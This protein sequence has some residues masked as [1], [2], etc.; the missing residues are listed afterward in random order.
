MLKIEGINKRFGS[1]EACKGINLEVRKGECFY[2][3]GP[4]GCGK[5]TLLSMI[6]GHLSPDSGDII[7]EGHSLLNMP[8][9][10]RPI[11]TIFQSY[12]LFPHLTVFENV[13]FSLRI[14]GV[15]D[16]EERVLKKLDLVSLLEFKD[17]YPEELS[18]GQQQRVAIARAIIDEPSLLLLDEPFGALDTKLRKEMQ[19]ELKALQ[20]SLGMTFICVTHDQEEALSLADRLAV[21]NS[22]SIEQLGTPENVYDSPATRFVASFIGESNILDGKVEGDKILLSNS[23]SVPITKKF[24]SGEIRGVVIRPE[25][26]ELNDGVSV[27]SLTGEVISRLFQGASILYL[28]KTELGKIKVLVPVD[29]DLSPRQIGDSVVVRCTSGSFEVV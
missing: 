28:I 10:K 26:F 13:A 20:R 15:V 27:F 2:L 18:G 12:A 19:L 6:A 25:W 5:S 21:M 24:Q 7:L 8:P 22:G 16:L 14:K 17:R 1:N 9:N 3:L 11:H 4:S 23:I 29:D